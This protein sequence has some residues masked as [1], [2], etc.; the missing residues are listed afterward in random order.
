MWSPCNHEHENMNNI[1]KNSF[2]SGILFLYFILIM[3]NQGHTQGTQN[4]DKVKLLWKAA[5]ENDVTTI[6]KLIQEGVNIEAND[7]KRRT[8]LMIATHKQNNEAAKALIDAGANV[9]ALDDMHDTPFL[10]A[11]AS[12]YTQIVS[13]CL[14]HGA[15]FTVFNRYNGTALIPACERGHV[16]TVKELLKRKDFPID[17]VNRLGWTAL[18]EAIILSDGGPAHVQI[19]QLLVNAGCNVN[20]ADKDGITPL[21]HARDKDFTQIV[22]ILEKAGA[23]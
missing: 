3:I 16:E 14:Q 7:K 23:K 2:K 20:I 5:E 12:G 22:A 6:K 9:N 18:L 4:N 1:I 8:A 17:H 11:G 10:Y 13:Y 19:V 21:K 15:D